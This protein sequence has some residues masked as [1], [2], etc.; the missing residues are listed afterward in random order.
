M[1]HQK[2][3]QKKSGRPKAVSFGGTRET[4]WFCG[5]KRKGT[6]A[7]KGAGRQ[8][9]TSTKL[10]LGERKETAATLQTK[11][12][13]ERKDKEMDETR[14][15]GVYPLRSQKRGRGGEQASCKKGNWGSG[16]NM[17]NRGLNVVKKK[18]KKKGRLGQ[19]KRN[20]SSVWT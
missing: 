10:R 3:H 7:A 19:L 17:K 6:E 14:E 18:E 4:S 11:K 12:H 2:G 16:G 20:L 13:N 9:V 15:G 5:G 8:R 1:H